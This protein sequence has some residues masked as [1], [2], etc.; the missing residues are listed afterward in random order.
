MSL[1]VQEVE[2]VEVNKTIHEEG[3]K[4]QEGTQTRGL[5]MEEDGS[6]VL[7]IPSP[8]RRPLIHPDPHPAPDQSDPPRPFTLPPHHSQIPT[9]T[10]TPHPDLL[11][12]HP[13]PLLTISTSTPDSSHLHTQPKP[14]IHLVSPRLTYICQLLPS[15]HLPSSHPPSRHI[16]GVSCDVATN[17][18]VPHNYILSI[19]PNGML[20]T[21]G[22]ECVRSFTP[23]SPT[24]PITPTSPLPYTYHPLKIPPMISPNTSFTTP[25]TPPTH[26]PSTYT[27]HPPPTHNPST[28]PSSTPPSTTP[29]THNSSTYTHHPPASPLKPE[30][31]V[32]CVRETVQHQQS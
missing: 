2:K 3:R 17:R 31:Q 1:A 23:A 21:P 14:I 18:D 27:H 19:E 6:V 16:H 24:T 20:Q 4:E 12:L 26:N 25:T 28:T 22:A 29:P 30:I 9:P 11:H 5:F 13:N 10:S 15:Y 32:T 7:K 8:P